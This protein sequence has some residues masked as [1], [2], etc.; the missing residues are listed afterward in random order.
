[1]SELGQNFT[2]LDEARRVVVGLKSFVFMIV[3]FL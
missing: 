3:H 1:M 2:V